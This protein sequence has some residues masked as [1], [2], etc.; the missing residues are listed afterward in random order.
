[1]YAQ[2]TRVCIFFKTVLVSILNNRLNNQPGHL[3][4][5]H[6]QGYLSEVHLNTSGESQLLNFR[7][8]SRMLHLL[9][10]RNMICPVSG[11]EA[12]ILAKHV[13]KLFNAIRI[14]C[15][16]EGIQNKEAV[17]QKMWINLGLKLS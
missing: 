17:V 2:E 8:D 11:N 9:L 16:G 14:S 4:L 5:F 12:E 6:L 7:I 1:M 10:Q 13:R 3:N 15:S